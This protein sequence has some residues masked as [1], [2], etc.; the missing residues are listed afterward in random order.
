MQNDNLFYR[1]LFVISLLAA[2]YLIY[3]NYCGVYSGIYDLNI[4]DVWAL[5]AVAVLF[6][7][8]V[9]ALFC[10]RKNKRYFRVP[11]LSFFVLLI[12]SGCLESKTMVV[13]EGC[14][15]SICHTLE[16]RRNGSY[17]LS[18]ACQ[19]VT[20]ESTGLYKLRHKNVV[21][22]DSKEW[23]EKPKEEDLT[24]I[25]EKG[26]VNCSSVVHRLNVGYL[27]VKE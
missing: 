16:L 21:L 15:M 3:W 2:V 13:L 8:N 23:V 14:E 1:L 11:I 25:K 19:A 24:F 9:I 10:L 4:V 5:I 20:T 12:L 18:S 7:T 6:L 27:E 17:C 22:Y 26:Y